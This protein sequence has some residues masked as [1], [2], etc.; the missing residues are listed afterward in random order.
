MSRP[1]T[2]YISICMDDPIGWSGGNPYCIFQPQV[3][4][5]PMDEVYSVA[6]DKDSSLMQEGT[7]AQ[8]I[9][10]QNAHLDR[11][12]TQA[13]VFGMGKISELSSTVRP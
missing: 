11:S 12:H 8:G 4:V 3:I 2:N 5:C 10:R 13:P 9:N 1:V 7:T 6:D